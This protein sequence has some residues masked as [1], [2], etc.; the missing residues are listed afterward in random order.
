VTGPTS[1]LPAVDTTVSEAAKRAS[2]WSVVHTSLTRDGSSQ[3][4]LLHGERLAPGST[5]TLTGKVVFAKGAKRATSV[6]K[7]T[8]TACAGPSAF[9]SL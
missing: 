8:F 5:H 1:C 3:A 6:A 7:L 2:G 4:A 9:G